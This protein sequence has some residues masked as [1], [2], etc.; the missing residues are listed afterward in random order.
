VERDLRCGG[1]SR[2]TRAIGLAWSM[3]ATVPTRPN[4]SRETRLLLS[5][6]FLSIAVLWVLARLRFPVDVA[7]PG[8]VPPL[9]TQLTPRST[10]DDLA[11]AISQLAPRV[12]GSIV[13][14]TAAGPG[15]LEEGALQ[16]RLPAV[17]VRADAGAV[18]MLPQR[19][20]AREP[21][22]PPARTS[23]LMACDPA[24][25][26]S[27]VRLSPS[28]TPQPEVW[29]PRAAPQPR[30]LI[31]ADVS[32]ERVSLQPVFVG[33][34]DAIA[35]PV[36][37]GSVWVV[38]RRTPLLAGTFV[39]TTEGAWAGLVVD[40]GS[41]QAI[42]P[43][44][45]VAGMARRLSTTEPGPSGALGIDVQP[46]TPAVAAAAGATAG[47]VV[48]SVDRDGPA[49]GKV[50]VTDVIEAVDGDA[51][52][53]EEHWRAR[54]ARV[55]TAES[56]VLRVR[57][58]N[59]ALEVVVTAAPAGGSRASSLLGVTLRVVRGRGSEIVGVQ[60]GSVAA[61]AGLEAGD[62][63]T[64]FGDRRAPTPAEILRHFADAA[65]SDK[66]L[67]ATSRD[68]TDRVSALEK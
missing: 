63:V 6:V 24:S 59:Q 30:Y 25:G 52:A 15:T 41:A 2:V 19:P 48:T 45:L 14:V 49:A 40:H 64:V 47:V 12:A 27:I 32:A 38:P 28:S 58:H 4:V 44:E 13:A 37:S 9:L 39:F 3:A 8:P 29:M 31:A 42:V 56:L 57:R 60:P 35:S 7:A 50:A 22:C 17:R 26:L 5:I 55:R 46:L 51:I 1:Q 16:R 10:F 34:F 66:V 11:L 18:L 43:A 33:G 68:G 53:T 20:E 65:P 62:V 23:D 61:R 36:W 54:S 67:V 21:R